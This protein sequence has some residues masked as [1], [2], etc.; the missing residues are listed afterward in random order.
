MEKILQHKDFNYDTGEND[1][2]LLKLGSKITVNNSKI[3]GLSTSKPKA[4][5]TATITGWGITVEDDDGMGSEVLQVIQ[6]PVL[7]QEDCKKS[8]VVEG[9]TD[10]MFC[11][12][13]LN[14]GGKDACTGD[15]GGPL[16]VDGVVAGIV[17]WSKGCA[18]PDRP[19]VYTD[20]ASFLD[21]IE[22]MT[23]SDE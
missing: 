16:V 7:D 13:L 4:N 23:S 10:T 1:I 12:G 15:S 2:S 3:I 20:V 19:G 8:F 6:L 14:V 22:E 9:V 21:W 18:R 5:E 17:S 11:A